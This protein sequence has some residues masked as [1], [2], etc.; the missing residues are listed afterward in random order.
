MLDQVQEV[1]KARFSE[2]QRLQEKVFLQRIHSI[3]GDIVYLDCPYLSNSAKVV[4]KRLYFPRKEEPLVSMWAC[5]LYFPASDVGPKCAE[6]QP[7]K[8]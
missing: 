8:A 4:P 3:G 1:Q 5:P 6:K 2:T 7:Q